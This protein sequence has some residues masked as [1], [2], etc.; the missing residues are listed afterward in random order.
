MFFR[1]GLQFPFRFGNGER[2][3]L[4]GILSQAVFTCKCNTCV[5]LRCRD[6]ADQNLEICL[7]LHGPHIAVV[8]A[9]YDRNMVD[10]SDLSDAY[11][12]VRGHISFEVSK[13]A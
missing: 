9:C 7:D 1:V 8:Y 11:Y 10:D 12:N 13:M 6:S 2:R 5:I 3:R 4:K